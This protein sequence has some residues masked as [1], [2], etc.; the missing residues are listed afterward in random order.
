MVDELELL[1]KDWQKQDESLPR[2]SKEDIYPM[3]L[4]KSSSIVK[5]ILII[6]IIEFVFWIAIAV[7]S[8]QQDLNTE[9]IEDAGVTTI[10]YILLVINYGAIIY[11]I[12]RFY[13]NYKTIQSTDSS[14]TLMANILKARRTVKQ[15]IWFNIAFLFIGMIVVFWIAYSNSPETF[16]VDNLA[17]LII[18][19]IAVTIIIAGLL[20]LIYRVIYGRLLKRLSNNYKELKKLEI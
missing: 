9:F 18:A 19:L 2:L 5:W 13:L 3:L 14:I 1:K 6:S 11:F 17:I 4:K 12:T 20:L 15:Y 7:I 8:E 16:N 10:N